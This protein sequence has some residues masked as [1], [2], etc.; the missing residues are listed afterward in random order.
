MAWDIQASPDPFQALIS[1]AI[2]QGFKPPLVLRFEDANGRGFTQTLR[3]DKSGNVLCS[4]N[5]EFLDGTTGDEPIVPPC[6]YILT[7]A[8]GKQ[9]VEVMIDPKQLN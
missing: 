5:P 8:A 4:E 7:D 3:V 9:G 1:K 6:T 2:E